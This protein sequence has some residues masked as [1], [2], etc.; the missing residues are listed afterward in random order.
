MVSLNSIT[1]NALT[2]T[3]IQ[4]ILVIDSVNSITSLTIAD[5]KINGDTYSS[6]SLENL[7]VGN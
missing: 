6:F 4:D 1:D 3:M 2:E 5:D 7:R